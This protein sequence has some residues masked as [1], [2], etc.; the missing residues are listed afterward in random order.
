MAWYICICHI[1]VKFYWTNNTL[2]LF[3]KWYPTNKE[4]FSCKLFPVLKFALL[5]DT[6]GPVWTTFNNF[7]P[8]WTTW[9]HLRSLGGHLGSLGVILG[10]FSYFG[11]LWVALG[12]FV[13]L[14]HLDNFGPF[15]T[16]FDHFQP[17][18][19]TF[20]QSQFGPVWKSLY[21]F[22]PFWT[23]LD[24]FWPHLA[25]FDQFDPLWVT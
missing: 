21:H 15:S 5:M 24:H 8:V 4:D 13:Q 12:H 25:T 17:H 1:T 20:D 11:S 19:T 14:G 7:G 10:H 3:R 2:T 9:G 23:I 22:G 6:F 16:T 18:L